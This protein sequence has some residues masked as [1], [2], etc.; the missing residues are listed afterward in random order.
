MLYVYELKQ[1]IVNYSSPRSAFQWW[2]MMADD[3]Y[4]LYTTALQLP[5]KL[6]PAVVPPPILVY[7][8]PLRTVVPPIMTVSL[9]QRRDRVGQRLCVYVGYLVVAM[10]PLHLL[11][12]LLLGLLKMQVHGSFEVNLLQRVVF[13]R[14]RRSERGDR[15]AQ[16]VVRCDG[17]PAGA[18]CVCCL[19]LDLLHH[20]PA[21]VEFVVR[22]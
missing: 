20:L 6:P 9:G 12:L 4:T 16:E 21:S 10:V 7:P 8:R 17:C 22:R 15:Y 5:S 3:V 14:G 19:A 18:P 2:L 13:M 11:L 1:L